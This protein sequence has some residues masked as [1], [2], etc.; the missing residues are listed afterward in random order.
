MNEA[1]I[2]QHLD[3]F[4]PL[5]IS[6]LKRKKLKKKKIL[7]TEVSCNASLAAQLALALANHSSIAM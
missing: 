4:Y 7:H 5:Y 6:K 3:N 1:F 2:H